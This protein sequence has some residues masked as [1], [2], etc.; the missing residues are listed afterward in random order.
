MSLQT[1]SFVLPMI[2]FLFRRIRTENPA[3]LR[4]QHTRVSSSARRRLPVYWNVESDLLQ[5]QSSGWS[6]FERWSYPGIQ[7]I[8][9]VFQF[10]L[11]SSNDHECSHEKPDHFVHEAVPRDEND[12]CARVGQF[13]P[14]IVGCYELNRESVGCKSCF[15]VLVCASRWGPVAHRKRRKNCAALPAIDRLE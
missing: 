14:V 6:A 13:K 12:K 9:Q 8:L 3:T 5:D 1:I 10:Q 4:T 15:G 11:L 7:R 2:A